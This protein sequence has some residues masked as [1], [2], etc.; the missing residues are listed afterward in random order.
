M[1]TN[2]RA[3]ALVLFLLLG[4]LWVPVKSAVVVSD[5]T[6]VQYNEILSTSTQSFKGKLTAGFP[7]LGTPEMSLVSNGTIGADHTWSTPEQISFVYDS[8]GNATMRAGSTLLVGQ[9][10]VGF[11]AVLIQMKDSA[12]FTFQTELRDITVNG[13]SVRNLFAKRT[14]Q[15]TDQIMVTGFGSEIDI[16]GS[17]FKNP[18]AAGEESNLT[19]TGIVIPEPSTLILSSGFLLLLRRKR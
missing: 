4:V 8:A 10:L 13:V 19:I 18:A 16:Q 12:P 11:N 6:A 5:L 17:F 7:S 3:V 2:L 1:K 14:T 15:S 9:P